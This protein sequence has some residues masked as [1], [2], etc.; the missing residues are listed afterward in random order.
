M[1]IYPFTLLISVHF[2]YLMIY[3]M[4]YWIL[5]YFFI[6][7]ETQNRGSIQAMPFVCA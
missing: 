7:A 6:L 2:L 3:L 4:F 1:F 5:I